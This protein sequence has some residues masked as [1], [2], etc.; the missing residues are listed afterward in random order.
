MRAEFIAAPPPLIVG[1]LFAGIGG[2]ER[3]M[4][5]TG[6]F[7]CG[8]Q[9]EIR[10]HALR[11]LARHYR[12]TPRYGDICG[13]NPATLPHVDVLV[14]GFP[15][16]DISDAG[17]CAGITGA[18]SGLWGQF[19]RLIEALR[20][21]LVFIEQ[22]EALRRR[23]MSVVL[24]DLFR[25]G[26]VAEWH[27]TPATAAGALHLRDRMYIVAT[28]RDLAT[29]ALLSNLDAYLSAFE[30][31]AA[32]D[33]APEIPRVASDVPLRAERLTGLGNSIVP[34]VVT[35]FTLAMLDAID[36]PTPA[37]TGLPQ[38]GWV[39]KGQWYTPKGAE[40]P[41]RWPRDGILTEDGAYALPV[42]RPSTY[43]DDRLLW[44]TPTVGDASGGRT[45]SKG[46]AYP[47]SLRAAVRGLNPKF[48]PLLGAGFVPPPRGVSLNPTWVDW[49]MGFPA[50]W[51]ALD[52]EDGE[53]I[54]LP[55]VPLLS[56]TLEIPEQIALPLF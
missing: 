9:S 36:A 51:T 24:A 4:E 20:P 13:I 10:P 17:L 12:D 55:P 34:Q 19:A 27:C 32:W 42:L 31:A 5:A 40:L 38:I 15:C 22:V 46:K 37:P 16:Q 39:H 21:R 3:A 33:E 26:Y 14:G 7:L 8:F 11:V 29:G 6:R 43:G 49:L 18:R 1:S 56:R 25:L 53:T 2:L 52:D 47:T 23:G 30:A 44:P 54:T 41:D 28:R 48:L 45:T 50:G 35:A